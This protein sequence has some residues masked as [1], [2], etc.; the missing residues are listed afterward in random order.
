MM[1]KVPEKILMMRSWLLNYSVMIL[2]VIAALLLTRLLVPVFDPSV[3]TLFYAAVAISAWYGGMGLG[4]VAIALSITTVVYFL[5]EPVYSFDFLSLNVLVR[6]TTFSLV[7]FL[8][9]ALS[10]ELRTARLSAE[11]SL[12]LLQNSE[13]RFSRLA[14]S[15]IIGVILTEIKNGSIIE[16]NDAFLKMVG[17]T[18][19]DLSANQMKWRQ[20]TPPE[21]LQLSEYS[22]EEL[23]TTGVC[24]P[25]EKEY[26]CK[27][28]DR[29]PVLL[30]SVLVGDTQET[31]IGFVV[32]LSER[33]Q[34]EAALQQANERNTRTLENMSD[35]FITLDRD[36]R[37]IYQN[38]EAE[39][40]NGKLRTE[41][42]GKSHWEEW[43]ASVGTNVERQYRRAMAEQIPVH[44]QHHYYYPS[45]Y[46][47][48]L[49]I[50]VYPCEDGL[51]IFF[52]DISDRKLAEK[53]VQASDERLRSFVKANIVGILFGD[54]NG[55]ITEANDEFLRI[56]GYTQEDIQAGRLCW[57]SNAIL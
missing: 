46:D 40:I 44:F 28:G 4:V 54:V 9:T 11:T 55:S 27:D 41:V 36:W 33:K 6:L 10:S 25:F 29:I 24:K 3:F 57:G 14:E 18:R 8:I 43:P 15:N 16:A 38:A 26:I 42:I 2:A 19:E 1:V 7:S 12:K 22:V 20:I 13:M 53:A 35:A 5:I 47:L 17:Y 45:K 52:R 49:E 31:V 32:D 21:Y 23:R 48:W 39:R 56:V 30:G 50:H 51:N 34:A 37:I